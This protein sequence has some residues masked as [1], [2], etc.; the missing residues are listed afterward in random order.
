MCGA[1]L[2]WQCAH[3]ENEALLFCCWSASYCSVSCQKEHWEREHSLQCCHK[4]PESV[5][6]TVNAQDCCWLMLVWF[7]VLDSD[8]VLLI[9]E[10]QNDLLWLQLL[11]HCICHCTFRLLC[12]TFTETV[13]YHNSFSVFSEILKVACWLL[14]L[15]IRVV[16]LTDF[17]RKFWKFIVIF[18][19]FVTI[20]DLSNNSAIDYIFT[21]ILKTLQQC[22]TLVVYMFFT[23]D[24]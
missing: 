22:L 19:K 20:V 15:M 8:A 16:S 18:G 23:I 1:L 24:V 4:H 9:A 6:P 2:A 11:F 13:S 5:P 3:C 21:R 10:S 12:C 17:V 7:F 14:M